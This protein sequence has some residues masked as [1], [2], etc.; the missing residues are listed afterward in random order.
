MWKPKI[1]PKPI[2]EEN[3]ISL[4]IGDEYEHALDAA[5]EEE[6]V[7]LAGD[8]WNCLIY[9]QFLNTIKVY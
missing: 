7:D 8:I 4:D 5:S 6:L 2:E 3:K 1:A 9:Q